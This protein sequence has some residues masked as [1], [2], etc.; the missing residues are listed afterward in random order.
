LSYPLAIIHF[1]GRGPKKYSDLQLACAVATC[2]RMRDVLIELGLVPYGGNYE[3]V[4]KRIAELGLDA[5]HLRSFRQ[6]ER[7]QATEAELTEAVR[8]SRSLAQV[9]IK[10]GFEPGG[11]RQQTLK[12]R[13]EQ[14]RLDT[15]HFVGQAW[16]RGSR[17]PVVPRRPLHDLLI[18]R[19]LVRTNTLKKRLIRDGLK[20][21]RC[22]MCA[23][24]TWNGHPIPLELDHVNGKRDDNRLEN[25]RVLCP[26]CHA[27]TD[28]YR[29]RNI[30]AASYS[31]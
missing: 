4:W 8:G 19:R 2:T 27:Q 25:L 1:M 11:G 23:R 16:R 17:I 15:S 31:V 14:L 3:N 20:E 7:L 24:D 6:G 12:R 9:L 13:I 28:T 18:A 26:N 22:E 30:G 29:G 5:S 21:P 10:L